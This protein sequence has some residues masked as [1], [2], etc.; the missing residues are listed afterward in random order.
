MKFV[1]RSKK[2]KR[3]VNGLIVYVDHLNEEHETQ[4]ARWV[5]VFLKLHWRHAAI[6]RYQS[7][8]KDKWKKIKFLNF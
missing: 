5:N 2:L 7:I 8:L 3:V 1:K 6:F 4:V